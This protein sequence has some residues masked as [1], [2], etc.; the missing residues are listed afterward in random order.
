MTIFNLES[1]K[2][3]VYNNQKKFLAIQ[4]DQERDDFKEVIHYFNHSD[5]DNVVLALNNEDDTDLE[6]SLHLFSEENI[7]FITF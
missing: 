7:S 5:F 4:I 2:F 3:E 1:C 6:K